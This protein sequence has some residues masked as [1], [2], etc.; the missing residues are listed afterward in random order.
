MIEVNNL[1]LSYLL[2]KP[3]KLTKKRTKILYET[4]KNITNSLDFINH[5]LQMNYIVWKAYLEEF[6]ALKLLNTDTNVPEMEQAFRNYLITIQGSFNEFEITEYYFNPEYEKI[7]EQEVSKHLNEFYKGYY[8][9]RLKDFRNIKF[10]TWNEFYL[11]ASKYP[12]LFPLFHSE[13][14]GKEFIKKRIIK[15]DS[16][17][18]V[19]SYLS[20]IYVKGKIYDR[21]HDD[22]E[23]IFDIRVLQGNIKK[24]RNPFVEF[25]NVCKQLNIAYNDQIPLSVYEG[26]ISEANRKKEEPKPKAADGR[27]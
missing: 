1:D 22:R 13:L 2:K 14:F 10:Y 12:D 27:L 16:L 9:E 20:D 7:F 26:Y 15:V 4:F 19:D 8:K 5:D 18:K 17:V 6:R 21:L 3:A 23:K 24:E 11:F 25:A